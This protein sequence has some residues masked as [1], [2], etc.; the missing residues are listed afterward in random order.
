LFFF[1]GFSYVA[2]LLGLHLADLLSTDRRW[3]DRIKTRQQMARQKGE[4]ALSDRGELARKPVAPNR[5]RG[6]ERATV[7][8]IT[9]GALNLT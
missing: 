1:L 8:Q 5:M 2:I 9:F 3:R 7:I 4:N 6:R